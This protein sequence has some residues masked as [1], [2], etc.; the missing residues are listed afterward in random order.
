L[1]SAAGGPGRSV[2]AVLTSHLDSPAR[3]S[4]TGFAETQIGQ[5]PY[6]VAEFDLTV[7]DRRYSDSRNSRAFSEPESA[8]RTGAQNK[9]SKKACL[10]LCYS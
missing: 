10:E 1:F 3:L 5:I 8:D 2:R 7:T 4:L 9:K 6:N